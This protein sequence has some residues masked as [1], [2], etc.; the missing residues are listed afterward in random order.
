M[1]VTE[2]MLNIIIY[3]I[4]KDLKS[5]FIESAFEL[6]TWLYNASNVLANAISEKEQK[7]LIEKWVKKYITQQVG[8][9]NNNNEFRFQ[10]RLKIVILMKCKI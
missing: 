5:Y 6:E 4:V 2:N 10:E 1:I 9:S 3:I 7:K 8:S